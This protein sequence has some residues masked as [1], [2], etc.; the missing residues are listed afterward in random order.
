[1]MVIKFLILFCIV[2]KS[3]SCEINSKKNIYSLSS[4]I[5]LL[6]E[7]LELLD[8]KSISAISIFHPVLNYSGKKLAG[9]V[10]L[11][12][13]AFKD[14]TDSIIFFDESKDLKRNLSKLENSIVIEVISRDLGSFE[15]YELSKKMI[16]PYLK[17]CKTKLALVDKRVNLIK[18]SLNKIDLKPIV[19]YLSHFSKSLKR[20]NLVIVNDGFVK[21]LITLTKIKTYP[22]SLGYVNW[23]GRIMKNLKDSHIHVGVEDN[24]NEKLEFKKLSNNIFNTSYRGALSPGIRQIFFLE[25]L[26]PKL[27]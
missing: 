23:S 14:K 22:S 21:S 11:T 17:N 25:K 19:F 20:P 15:A 24:K 10:F 7:E 18:R 5:T 13:K 9:G 2:F 6:L 3:Y 26:I 16:K 4:P 27:L 12:E 1:M 8:S